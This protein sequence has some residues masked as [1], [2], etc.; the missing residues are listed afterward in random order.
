M[1]V[2][3][4]LCGSDRRSDCLLT[5]VAVW[6]GAGAADL[7]FHWLADDEPTDNISHEEVRLNGMGSW[8]VGPLSRQEAENSL[9]QY[10]AGTLLVRQ[11]GPKTVMSVK[12]SGGNY[13]HLMVK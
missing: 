10:P 3:M 9:D 13:N 8:F 7:L 12:H 2:C 6:I 1:N 4:Q 11:S 5:C